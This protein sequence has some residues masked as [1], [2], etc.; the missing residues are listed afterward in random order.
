M[1]GRRYIPPSLA[2]IRPWIHTG[3][4]ELLHILLFLQKEDTNVLYFFE[5]KY[6]CPV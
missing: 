4:I 1:L 3:I 5:L 6:L 2:Q